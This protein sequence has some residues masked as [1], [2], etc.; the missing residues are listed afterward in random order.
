MPEIFELCDRVTVMRDGKSIK[1]LNVK[2]TN[3]DELVTLMVNRK[4]SE[5]F[6]PRITPVGDTVLEA[7]GLCGNGVED[8]SFHLGRGE[9]L[10]FA[11]LVGTGRTETL[12]LVYGADKMDKGEILLE[13]K[14]VKIKSP[15]DALKHGI[16]LI[17]EDR[18]LQG[19]LLKMTIK[20]N[21]NVSVLK[22]DAHGILV[23]H[24]QETKNA[25][26][27][28]ESLRI[29]TPS[30]LQAAQNLSGGNQQKV[31]LAKSLATTA[32]VLIM[33]EPTRGI[34][35]GAK[36]EI[37]ELMR[38]LSEQGMSIIMISSEMD[39]LLG[40]SDRVMVMSEGRLAGEL[41]REEFDQE[42]ILDM[43]SGD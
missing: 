36:Q 22:R 29:R 11:G 42:R 15:Q 14:P 1:T 25:K 33:D 2:D 35:V 38:E 17:P 13:G 34:D 6:P 19:V 8:I 37:Y 27:Y 23:D 26:D 7:K 32:K 21:I 3:R 20:A 12:R 28:I 9:I 18:K 39:E 43:A 24:K 41:S 30:M 40:M 31:A 10:G 5:S 16:A 4:L